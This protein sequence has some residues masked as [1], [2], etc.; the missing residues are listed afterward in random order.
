TRSD[1][2]SGDLQGLLRHLHRGPV[3]LLMTHPTEHCELDSSRVV[4]R[5]AGHG[6][7]V[8]PDE[9]G[10][11]RPA[12]A[13]VSLLQWHVILLVPGRQS[14]YVHVASRTAGSEERERVPSLVV[15]HV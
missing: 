8:G 10:S 4:A 11:R 3:P 12:L 5:V 15:V 2:A 1:A 7:I 9:G 14:G 13:L 6:A